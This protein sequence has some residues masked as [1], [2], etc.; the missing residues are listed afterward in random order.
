M[1]IWVPATFAKLA[2]DN[3]AIACEDE[4]LNNPA[5]ISTSS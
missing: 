4:T 1:C 5:T 3:L 2:V